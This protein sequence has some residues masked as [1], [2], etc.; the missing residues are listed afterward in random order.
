[1][2]R[3]GLCFLLAGVALCAFCQH[4]EGGTA[5]AR[6]GEPDG[7]VIVIDRKSRRLCAYNGTGKTKLLSCSIGVGR[8]GLKQKKSMNDLVTPTGKF[9]V[10]IILSN[11][12]STV[13]ISDSLRRKLLRDS[14]YASYVQSAAGLVRLFANM[15][16]ID[17]DGNGKPDAA[18]GAGYIGLNSGADTLHDQSTA[19]VTGPK[20]SLFNG[21]P[22]WFS[23]ALHGTPTPSKAIGKATS[24]G[25]VHVPFECLSGLLK[26]VKVGTAVEIHD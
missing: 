15:N 20:A 4:S 17:F 9:I 8:G 2:S 26:M 12:S 13:Q 5:S 10:D 14:R 25:C 6:D 21:T 1:M 7:A 22:Y 18:Y 24:G 23:I 11:D 3:K 19:S 16:S